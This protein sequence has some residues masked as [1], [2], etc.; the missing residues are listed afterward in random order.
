MAF[1]LDCLGWG[2]SVITA[3]LGRKSNP[4]ACLDKSQHDQD[5]EHHLSKTCAVCEQHSVTNM[6]SV[7][8][9]RYSW[10][11]VVADE[12]LYFSL[13]MAPKKTISR[14]NTQTGDKL[15]KRNRK[16]VI[17]V[18]SKDVPWNLLV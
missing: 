13:V 15:W 17:S 8:L 5:L 7:L 12:T 6:E 9:I 18:L 4:L 2:I 14:Y 10:S 3:D 16:H 11:T 1:C